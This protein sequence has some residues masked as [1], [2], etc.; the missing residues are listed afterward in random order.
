MAD[1]TAIKNSPNRL[2]A[3]I[4]GAV[5]IVVGLLGFTV[6]AGLPFFT[7]DGDLLLG[8]FEVNNFHNVAHLLIGAALLF[9]GLKSIPAAKTANLVVGA[10]YLLLGIIGLF[11]I[12]SPA[13]ILA[14]NGADNVLHFASAAVLLA[15]ALGTDKNP[16]ARV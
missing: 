5:Y 12:E 3:V 10:A 9:A 7:N 15:V 2:V 8:I 1:T 4:F 6:S 16:R 11:I 14:I 13:N